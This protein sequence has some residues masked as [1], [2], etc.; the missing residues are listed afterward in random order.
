LSRN[1]VTNKAVNILTII[2]ISSVTA[3]PLTE[4]EPRKYN[5]SAAIIVVM[6][7]SKIDDN[8]LL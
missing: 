7:E 8:A 5:T 6:L 1:F 3:N 4:P 2:P